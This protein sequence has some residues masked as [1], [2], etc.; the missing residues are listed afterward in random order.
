MKWWK[1]LKNEKMSEYSDKNR[2]DYE[3]NNN[4]KETKEVWKD[5]VGYERWYEVSNLG[6]VRKINR[7]GTTKILKAKPNT[8]GRTA[9]LR[10]VG[11]VKT[12]QVSHLVAE[13]FKVPTT[14]TNK[15]NVYHIDGDVNNDCLSNL[16]YDKKETDKYKEEHKDDMLEFVAK[17]EERKEELFNYIENNRV[18]LQ[19]A[20]ANKEVGLKEINDTLNKIL[21][22]LKTHLK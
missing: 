9:G 4:K 22:L 10:K 14:D 2:I 1:S 12:Y 5:V 13:A 16:T 6:N 18:F 19:Q 8:K 7:D 11:N 21:D 17:N 3:Q 20:K 15:N